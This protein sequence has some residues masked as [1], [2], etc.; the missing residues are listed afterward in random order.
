MDHKPH[1]LL[2]DDDEDTRRIFG[3]HLSKSDF[4]VI[5][6]EDGNECREMARR[7]QPDIILLDYHLPI[8]DGLETAKVLKGESET[9]HIPIILFTNADL[10]LESEKAFRE[11]GISDYVHKSIEPPL[12]IDRIKNVLAQNAST[13]PR[14]IWVG[15]KPVVAA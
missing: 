5:Y 10:S 6:A 1:I 13:K 8:M 11:V 7:F 15:P 4:E 12:L 9:S 14:I 3:H 2:A